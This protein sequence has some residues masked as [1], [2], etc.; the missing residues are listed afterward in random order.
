MPNDV[1]AVYDYQK[2]MGLGILAG[3]FA[4]ALASAVS[5]GALSRM[6]VPQLNLMK[7]LGSLFFRRFDVKGLHAYQLDKWPTLIFW[8][9]PA[10]VGW[11][12][13]ALKN[14]NGKS[15]DLIERFT[16]AACGTFSFFFLS[17]MVLRP[18]ARLNFMQQSAARFFV[19]EAENMDKNMF[20]H[21]E[22]A[23]MRTVQTLQQKHGW[24]KN[25]KLDSRITIP[26]FEDIIKLAE[27]NPEFTQEIAQSAL[28]WKTW[29]FGKELGITIAA[30]GMFPI[31]LNWYLTGKRHAKEQ[32][33]LT[34]PPPPPLY[35]SLAKLQLTPAP[36]GVTSALGQTKNTMMTLANASLP[37]QA[38]SLSTLNAYNNIVPFNTPPRQNSMATSGAEQHF[39]TAPQ[40]AK[41]TASSDTPSKPTP[42]MDAFSQF[43][44]HP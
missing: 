38:T 31:F 24:F 6:K 2:K 35:P 12:H 41:V 40:F 43:K 20:E 42:E 11:M 17:P 8:L 19:K 44:T 30:M 4:A 16:Q 29:Q 21:A 37:V 14:K 10:Y 3:G 39:T 15:D 27:K 33:T 26:D 9:A 25:L 36:L 28:K 23:A 5:L 7:G 18:L 34:P 32:P 1:K 22:D 13:S